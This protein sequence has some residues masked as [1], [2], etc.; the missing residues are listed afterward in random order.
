MTE[1]CVDGRIL[2]N[3]IETGALA[4][5]GLHS[6]QIG[7][8]NGLHHES[9]LVLEEALCDPRPVVSLRVAANPRQPHEF[10]ELSR[11]SVGQ[12]ATAMLALVFATGTGPLIIDQ[13][14][15]DLDNAFV[16]DFVVENLRASKNARQVIIATHNAN[17][18]VLGDAELICCLSAEYRDGEPI[19][20]VVAAGAIDEEAVTLS[21]TKVLE[22]G[23]AA[24]EERSRRYGF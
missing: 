16:A 24:F 19:A 1:R 10:R 14:E 13:P 6:R 8:L 9:R 11:L 17:L 15:D 22:G 5:L 20:S 4:E 21:V 12:R 7:V 18:P 3:G 2:V 23:R